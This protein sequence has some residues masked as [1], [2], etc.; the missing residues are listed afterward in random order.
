MTETKNQYDKTFVWVKPGEAY[1][2][3]YERFHEFCQDFIR[4]FDLNKQKNGT[5]GLYIIINGLSFDVSHFCSEFPDAKDN[6][7]YMKYR[8]LIGI[9]REGD[10]RLTATYNN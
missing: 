1:W 5:L 8:D 2:H 10:V 9:G 3:G 6:L 7:E 4:L